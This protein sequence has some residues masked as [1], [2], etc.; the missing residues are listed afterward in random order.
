M[1]RTTL[2]LTGAILER[3]SSGMVDRAPDQGSQLHVEDLTTYPS[4]LAK[5]RRIEA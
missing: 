1:S 2:V 4:A 3:H 5:E